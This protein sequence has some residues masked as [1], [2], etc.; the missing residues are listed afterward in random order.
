MNSLEDK[1]FEEDF[2][3]KIQND[4]ITPKPKWQF[5]LKN[6][7]IWGLGAFS[8]I[9]GSISMSLI[10]FM[11]SNEDSGV[12]QLSDNNIWDTLL[13]VV[14]FFWIICLAVFAFAVY[15]YIKH[16][17]KGYKYSANKIIL[18][19]LAASLLFGAALDVFGLDRVID[20]TLG[21]RAPYYDRVINPRLNYWSN[22]DN[23]RLTGLVVTEVS[24]VEYDL[25]DL[26]GEIWVTLLTDEDQ[27]GVMVV[28]HPVRLVGKN[29][30]DH[31]FMVKD[32]LPVGPGRGF[33][34]RPLPPRRPIPCEINSDTN[35]SSC[36]L[37][38]TVPPI[39]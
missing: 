18:T 9:L 27:S 28:D 21:Q 37:Q 29:L 19:I 24:P 36:D 7:I 13:I 1:K 10:Y 4:K 5:L 3:H 38:F 26:G 8:L 35:S 20:D 39:N 22:P 17:K 30:G 32:I 15:Y 11:I 31:K 34:R 16:T 14:P 33:F 2:L 6:S 23:G 12:Y 25:V